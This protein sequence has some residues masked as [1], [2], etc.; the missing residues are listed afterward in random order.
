MRVPKVDG[1][2]AL[3]LKRDALIAVG[4]AKQYLY[5]DTASGKNDDRPDLAAV[6]DRFATATRVSYGNSTAAVA[7]SGA[8]ST[9]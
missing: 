7:F 9:P 5:S 4:V 3:D 6:C 1:S 2:Q 8:S